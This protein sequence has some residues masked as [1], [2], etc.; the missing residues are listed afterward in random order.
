MTTN[1]IEVHSARLSLSGVNHQ[2][3]KNGSSVQVRIIKSFG[4]CK[5]EGSVAGVRVNISS[6]R[7]LKTGQSFV[8]TVNAKNGTIFLTPNDSENEALNITFSEVPENSLK[9]FLSSLGLPAD[10]ISVSVL[11]LFKQM[12][13]KID[14][15][16]IS[17]IRNF[18]LRFSGKEKLASEI[19]SIISE[20]SLE[21]SE[22]EI[23]QLILL[24]D[25]K[26]NGFERGEFLQGK[27][28]LK[29]INS[30]AGAWFIVP[31][32][33][34]QL[35]DSDF[36]EQKSEV[37]CGNGC[38]RLL[39]DSAQKLKQLNLESFYQNQKYLFS[40]IFDGQKISD[41]KFNVSNA[42]SF[43]SEI[44]RLKKH[45][46]AA[47]VNVQKINWEEASLLEGCASGL[48]S[49]YAFGGNV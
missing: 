48:E 39:F 36:A 20:K 24:L 38:I 5:Y 40:L 30:T 1:G 2:I 31:F 15:A 42:K 3:L 11:Q 4:N 32:D 46:A 29:K 16:L 23:N 7:P 33:L 28:L 6:S 41:V 9:T 14:S 13:L 35:S 37:V 26:E 21:A 22:Q 27:N 10:S 12:G 8:A 43:D 25:E 45:F 18:A 44:V 47:S 49:F 17:K 19:L 34:I